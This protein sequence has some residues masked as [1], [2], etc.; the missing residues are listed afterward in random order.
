MEFTRKTRLGSRA[1]NNR[2]QGCL[3]SLY[4]ALL[5]GIAPGVS[6]GTGCKAWSRCRLRR[7]DW[8]CQGMLKCRVT[9]Q[10]EFSR[11]YPAPDLTPAGRADRS[12]SE[13]SSAYSDPLHPWPLA[14][15]PYSLP[16][17]GAECAYRALPLAE[18]PLPSS[19][20]KLCAHWALNGP[21]WSSSMS[22]SSRKASSA[23]YTIPCRP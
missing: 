15:G 22:A 12:G 9:S 18:T 14:G 11:F 13:P 21:N 20:G 5:R 1:G 8:Q 16:R 4:P 19:S 23:Q 10:F 3:P 2:H 17:R 6:D 7:R